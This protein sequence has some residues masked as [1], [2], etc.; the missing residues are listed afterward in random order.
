[1]AE[2][3]NPDRP[4]TLVVDFGVLPARP[5]AAIVHDFLM[6]A[7]N[8]Q[9]ADV[10]QIQFHNIRKCVFIQMTSFEVACRYEEEHNLK[11]AFPFKG[12]KFAI[13]V[14]VDRGLT[15]V[16]VHDLPPTVSNTTVHEFMQQFGTVSSVSKER[17]KHYFPGIFNGVRIIHIILKQPIPSYITISGFQTYC[18]YIGQQS[19]CR[20]CSK[21][22]HPKQK[23]AESTAIPSCS[24]PSTHTK[25]ASEAISETDFPPL[26]TGQG[27]SSTIDNSDID[28]IHDNAS[29][30]ISATTAEDTTG[31]TK[32][33]LSTEEQHEKKKVCA[34][35]CFPNENQSNDKAR[36]GKNEFSSPAGGNVIL[37]NKSGKGNHGNK[38]QNLSAL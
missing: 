1:M 15:T 3:M 14:Y 2:T 35:Q 22:A 21:A 25:P 9:L 36:S 19:T 38:N 7:I 29:S 18:S 5:D 28:S 10:K 23:C 24:K 4:D 17:W 11:H 37:K 20:V 26:T 32:R 34:D 16:R 6:E 8:L 30:S 33:R 12:K 27:P 31:T 13:H